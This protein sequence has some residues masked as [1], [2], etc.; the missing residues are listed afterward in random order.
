MQQKLGHIDVCEDISAYAPSVPYE[1]KLLN[2]NIYRVWN[3]L[4][5]P[6]QPQ[7]QTSRKINKYSI[8]ISSMSDSCAKFHESELIFNHWKWFFYWTCPKSMLFRCYMYR[9]SEMFVVEAMEGRGGAKVL[10][11]PVY[12]TF[13]VKNYVY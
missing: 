9:F 1:I 6:P 7:L 4:R 5:P 8:K 2:L 10:S 12:R 13:Q 3:D 11:N